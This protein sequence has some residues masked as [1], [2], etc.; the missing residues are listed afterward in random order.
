[1][2]V[3]RNYLYVLCYQLPLIASIAQT[4]FSHRIPEIQHKSDLLSEVPIR[5]L[6]EFTS[7]QY[8]ATKALTLVVEVVFP[9]VIAEIGLL[10]SI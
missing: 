8:A 4:V 2:C 7:Y 6:R 3:Q 1:M 10:P 9:L 5:H